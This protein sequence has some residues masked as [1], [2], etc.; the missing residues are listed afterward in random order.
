MVDPDLLEKAHKSGLEVGVV[1][2]EVLKKLNSDL[3]T[4]QPDLVERMKT[5]TQ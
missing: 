1:R 5:Y 4:T 2:G 3:A